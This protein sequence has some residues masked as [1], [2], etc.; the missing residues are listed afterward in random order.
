MTQKS[1]EITAVRHEDR[2][3]RG[4]VTVAGKT[5]VTQRTPRLELACARALL[6]ALEALL[7]AD[8]EDVRRDVVVQ[9]AHQLARAADVMKQWTVARSE[10]ESSTPAHDRALKSAHRSPGVD[11]EQRMDRQTG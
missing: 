8:E 11:T 5:R 4:P 2:K 1:P 6:D 10:E 9:V 7:D 3:E